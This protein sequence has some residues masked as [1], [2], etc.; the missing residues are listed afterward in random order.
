MFS[1]TPGKRA[2]LI[3]LEKNPLTIDAQLLADI[4]VMETFSSY[5][6]FYVSK[7]ASKCNIKI[8]LGEVFLSA[9]LYN[10]IIGFIE[11]KP[12]GSRGEVI[13]VNRG[14]FKI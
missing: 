7:N 4:K 6:D 14:A 13:Y 10:C 8:N 1:S 12:D 2:D 9:G 3:I 11:R 5:S